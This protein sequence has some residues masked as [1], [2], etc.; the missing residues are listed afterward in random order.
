M[1][2][3]T[4]RS[5]VRPRQTI[6]GTDGAIVNRIQF[7]YVAMVENDVVDTSGSL[8]DMH[9]MKANTGVRVDYSLSPPVTT[10][11]EFT[12]NYIV[13]YGRASPVN[14]PSNVAFRDDNAAISQ[15]DLQAGSATFTSKNKGV[16]DAAVYPFDWGTRNVG[17]SQDDYSILG[18]VIYI[19]TTSTPGQ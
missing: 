2:V 5:D 10:V 15:N 19:W 7:D 8:K 4:V 9:P 12:G 16:G 11:A 3:R 18:V 6:Y 1:A 13:A 14:R 17:M